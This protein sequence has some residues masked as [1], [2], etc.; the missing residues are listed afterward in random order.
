MWSK[1]AYL[2]DCKSA[3]FAPLCQLEPKFFKFLYF[4]SQPCGLYDCK[5]HQCYLLEY[6]NNSSSNSSESAGFC[7]SL[8]ISMHLLVHVAYFCGCRVLVEAVAQRCSVKNVFLEISH[9]SQEN[10]CARVSFL[11]KL[12]TFSYRTPPLAASVR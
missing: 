5:K 11:I 9:D 7:K 6:S 1:T 2:D 12:N 3:C 4:H 8:W 10:T